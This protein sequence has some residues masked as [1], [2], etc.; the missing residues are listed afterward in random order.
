MAI[1]AREV[2]RD[3]ISVTSAG[4]FGLVARKRRWSSCARAH[5][6]SSFR[7]LSEST[8]GCGTPSLLQRLVSDPVHQPTVRACVGRQLEVATGPFPKQ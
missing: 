7:A 4:V 6:S 2:D 5:R 8:N 1:Q 3:G